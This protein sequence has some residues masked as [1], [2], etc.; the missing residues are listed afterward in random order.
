[1]PRVD[2]GGLHLH[3]EELGDGEP[4]L[5]IM[6]VGGQLTLWPRAFVENLANR[7]FRTI[8]F[9]NRDVG[10]S[11]SLDHIAPPSLP[12]LLKAK[13][14]RTRPKTIGYDLHDMARDAIGLLDALELPHAHVVG[15]S[16]GGMIAQ[17]CAIEHPE[18]VR[19]LTSI[20]SSPGDSLSSLGDPRVLQT[21]LQQ[22]PTNAA[23]AGDS[24]VILA[25]AFNAGGLPLD[26]DLIR[27]L[28]SADFERSQNPAGFARQFAAIMATRNRKRTL[29]RVRCPS[30]IIHGTHDPLVPPRGGKLTAKLIPGATLQMVPRMGHS[31]HPLHWDAM[32]DGIQRCT[33]RW[34]DPAA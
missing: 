5:L 30:H 29:G 33:E 23:E 6:G 12:Q 7:G 8:R 25:H 10:L 17:I 14:S 22:R 19:T 13:V 1:M 20:M 28:G 27:R 4:L 32:A 34:Q 21:L 16:M 24:R 15:V 9:D 26:E 18:R 3:I 11:D 31:M 2:I